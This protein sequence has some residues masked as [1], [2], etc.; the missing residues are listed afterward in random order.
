M[1]PEEDG[2]RRLWGMSTAEVTILVA[3]SWSV[4]DHSSPEKIEHRESHLQLIFNLIPSAK[5]DH[6]WLFQISFSD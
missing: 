2:D 1:A 3:V 6:S 5:W 4:D